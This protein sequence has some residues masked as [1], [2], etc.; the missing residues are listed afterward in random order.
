WVD[1]FEIPRAS[2]NRLVVLRLSNAFIDNRQ[3]VVI[4]VSGQEEPV[5]PLRVDTRLGMVYATLPAGAIR[6]KYTSGFPLE[7]EDTKKF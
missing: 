5:E 4:E 7:N 2:A 6:V 1:H 3:S